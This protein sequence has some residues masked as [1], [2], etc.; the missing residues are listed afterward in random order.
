MIRGWPMVSQLTSFCLMIPP[1]FVTHLFSFD[2]SNMLL[3]TL[4]LI[5]LFLFRHSRRWDMI[6]LDYKVCIHLPS[7]FYIWSLQKYTLL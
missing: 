6:F 7:T 4:R 2:R 5:L 3:C 1:I